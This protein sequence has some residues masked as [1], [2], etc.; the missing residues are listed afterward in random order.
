MAVNFAKDD[1]CKIATPPQGWGPYLIKGTNASELIKGTSVAAGPGD[2]TVQGGNKDDVFVAA[3]AQTVCNRALAMI[4][5]MAG[6]AT[7]RSVAVPAMMLF[8]ADRGMTRSPAAPVTIASG[9][10]RA[11]I[12]SPAPPRAMI[13][14]T[15]AHGPTPSMAAS[16]MTL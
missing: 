2:D 16:T 1:D 10:A 15:A 3:R 6:R 5:S 11:T 7:I 12:Q 9:A 8:S 4:P 14:S 13:A